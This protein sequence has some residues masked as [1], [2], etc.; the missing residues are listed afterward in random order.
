MTDEQRKQDMETI[1]IKNGRTGGVLYS[2]SQVDNTIK[3]TLEKALREDA[4]LSYASLRGASLRGA[5]LSGADLS[6][7][8]LRGANLS[9]ADLSYADLSGAYLSGKYFQ[10][11]RIGSASRMT[12]YSVDDDIIWCGCFKGTMKEFEDKVR[13]THKDNELYLNEYLNAIEYLKKQ[14]KLYKK[15]PNGNQ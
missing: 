10:L 15:L 3:I 5:N 13:I 12:T 9:G 1:G 2:H 11:S 7:A 6:G 4:S 14:A 8:D